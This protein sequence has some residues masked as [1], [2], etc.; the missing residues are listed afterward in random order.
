[1]TTSKREKKI[2]S[3]AKRTRKSSL[4]PRL[5]SLPDQ[6]YEAFKTDIIQGVHKAEDSLNEVFLA[7]L[8]ATSRT[9]V[10]EAAARLA[11]EGLLQYIPQK[12]YFV[13]RISLSQL[14]K[15]FEYRIIIE[16]ATGELAAKREPDLI[17][18]Q[19][20]RTLA[21][22]SYEPI[23]RAS[24]I[25]FAKA[26]T[27]FHMT[28][29]R[30]TRNER[31]IRAVDEIRA[32]VEWL[33]YSALQAGSFVPRLVS[34]HMEIYEAIKARDSEK[35]REAMRRHLLSALANLPQML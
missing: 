12:G 30:L 27:G 1:M 24:H 34:D 32:Q 4:R 10:R 25:R 29:A 28:I 14:N 15:L 11:R 16:C 17:L 5:L 26:D 19:Q 8:Y 23:D 3:P 20:L 22:A 21:E 31:L 13:Q 7:D 9:P 35:S 2:P 33:L 6:V 18:L